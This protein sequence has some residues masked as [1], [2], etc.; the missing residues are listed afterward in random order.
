MR[1]V[2]IMAGLVAIGALLIVLLWVREVR[3]PV[4]EGR[5]AAS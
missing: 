3:I 2:T 5:A 4:Q 1:P